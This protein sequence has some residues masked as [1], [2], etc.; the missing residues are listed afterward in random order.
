MRLNATAMF[1]INRKTV[2][3]EIGEPVEIL[4]FKNYSVLIYDKAYIK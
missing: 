1:G 4:D 2:T 3:A